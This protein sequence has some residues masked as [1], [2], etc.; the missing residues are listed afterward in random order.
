LDNDTEKTVDASPGSIKAIKQGGMPSYR[1][2]ELGDLYVHLNVTFP[3]SLPETSF[4]FLEKALPPRAEVETLS[5]QQHADEVMLEEVDEAS[6]RRRE[7]AA[8][9]AMDEDDDAQPRVQC[10]NQCMLLCTPLCLGRY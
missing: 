1:H 9:D 3:E 10:A 6:A 2:H 5:P 8:S 4:P 7:A